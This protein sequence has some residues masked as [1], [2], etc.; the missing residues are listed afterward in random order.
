MKELDRYIKECNLVF[1]DT[2]DRLDFCRTDFD[3]DKT[4]VNFSDS[5]SLFHLVSSFNKL[6]LAFKKEYDELEKLKLGKKVEVV[7]FNKFSLQND[8]YRVLSAYIEVP[9]II[10]RPDTILYLR[11]INGEMKPFVTNN[12]NPFDKYYYRTDVK[13]DSDISKKYLDLFEKYSLLLESYNYLKNRQIFGDGTNSI[14]TSIDD[15]ES[16]LLDGLK[17]F[18]LYFGS[19]YF[20]TE[21]FVDV[22]FNLGENFGLDYEECKIRLDSKDKTVSEID[23]DDI[24]KKVYVNKTHIKERRK[25]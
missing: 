16:N 2:V 20:N 12:K 6:Y 9:I 24:I 14:F 5:I 8:N 4:E 19:N 21:Y 17:K 3:L 23:Y 25:K 10:N 7:G 13:L 22:I 18:K 11:E 1:T 15:Y